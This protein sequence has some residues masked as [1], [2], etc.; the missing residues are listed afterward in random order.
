V[1]KTALIVVA[2]LELALAGCRKKGGDGGATPTKL[3]KLGLTI[4]VPGDVAVDDAQGGGY[5]LLERNLGMLVVEPDEDPP[6]TLEA[7][8][9]DAAILKHEKLTAETLPDGFLATY[10]A[11]PGSIHTVEVHRT[12]RGKHYICSTM[13]AG[14]SGAQQAAASLAAC[15]SLK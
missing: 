5:M 11:M 9:S 1:S 2:V 8:K 7:V 13:A 3:P 6:R 14:A 4:S 12:I 10:V 15:K